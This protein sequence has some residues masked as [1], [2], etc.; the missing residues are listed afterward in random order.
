MPL[1][2]S[3]IE[4]TGIEA[5]VGDGHRARRPRD[6]DEHAAGLLV[7]AEAVSDRGRRRGCEGGRGAWAPSGSAGRAG[8]WEAAPPGAE[9]QGRATGRGREGQI[10]AE[11]KAVRVERHQAHV[12]DGALGQPRDTALHRDGSL[13][14][15]RRGLGVRAVGRRR[16]DVEPIGGRPLVGVDRAV[17]RRRGVRDVGWRQRLGHRSSVAVVRLSSRD[18]ERAGGGQRSKHGHE[19]TSKTWHPTSIGRSRQRPLSGLDQRA[20]GQEM[21]FVAA[22]TI[23]MSPSVM[24]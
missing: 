11:R 4:P 12:V 18:G 15:G 1:R 5:A 20:S 24:R 6:A 16:A 23:T 9:A 7:D 13:L 14:V 19:K 21:T 17:Q 2:A 10:G 8:R 22:S 3:T